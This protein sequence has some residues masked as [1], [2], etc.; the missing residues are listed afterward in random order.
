L[1]ENKNDEFNNEIKK[2]ADNISASIQELEDFIKNCGYNINENICLGEIRAICLPR[3]Y[4]RKLDEIE[5]KYKLDSIED[6]TLSKNI[7]YMIQYSDLTNYLLNRTTLC[8]E[9]SLSV[10][11]TFRKI[12]TINIATIVEALLAAKIETISRFCDTCN[13]PLERSCFLKKNS[14]SSNCLKRMKEYAK[15]NSYPTFNW[16]INFFHETEVIS[17]NFCDHLN[18]LREMRNH[19]HVQY[20]VR[21]NKKRVRD[22]MEKIYKIKDYNKAV[23]ILGKLPNLFD[24]IDSS[25]SCIYSYQ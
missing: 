15:R 8:D 2:R 14:S 25:F 1:N 12:C 23:R 18:W 4:F 6:K 3:G 22:F 7:A 24:K 19:V 10:G 21:K 5:K 13:H 17:K 16:L 20:I 11:N 9:S